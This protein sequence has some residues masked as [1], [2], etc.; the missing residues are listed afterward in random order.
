MN[1]RLIKDC[2]IEA[3]AEMISKSINSMNDF[4]PPSIIKASISHFNTNTIKQKINGHFYVVTKNKKIIGCGGI[5]K[6]Y[7]DKKYGIIFCVFID[8][9]YQR[10]GIGKKLLQKLESDSILE[11]CNKILVPSSIPAVPF[12]RKCGYEHINGILNFDN[13]KFWLE[14][15][16]KNE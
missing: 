4:Y 13:T 12:Y 8:P 10:Q 5:D 2:E 7:N 9:E 11:N 16:I 3:C 1:I 15:R 6:K 14:R